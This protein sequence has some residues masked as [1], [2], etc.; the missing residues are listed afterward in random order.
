MPKLAVMS[1]GLC[2]FADRY[3]P[4]LNLSMLHLLK[5]MYTGKS[6]NPVPEIFSLV[7]ENL[8]AK[9]NL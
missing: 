1:R 4:Y 3:Y 2:N 5:G 6:A 7:P 8:R 9:R